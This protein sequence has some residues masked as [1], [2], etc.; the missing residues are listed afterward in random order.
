MELTVFPSRD[1]RISERTVEQFVDIPVYGRGAS[2]RG[3]PQDSVPAVP[4]QGGG[5]GGRGGGG[6]GGGADVMHC[7]CV[8]H[9]RKLRAT[10]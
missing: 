2:P 1:E 5:G 9:T 8:C 10:S 7:A 4:G 3:G 6:G